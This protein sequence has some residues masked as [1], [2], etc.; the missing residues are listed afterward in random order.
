MTHADRGL[1]PGHLA[2]LDEVVLGEVSG[3]DYLRAEIGA[4]WWK[5]SN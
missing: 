1:N 3:P 2:A 5:L 4:R